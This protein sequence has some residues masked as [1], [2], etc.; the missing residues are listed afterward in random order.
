MLLSMR[1]WSWW[2]DPLHAYP[3]RSRLRESC[4][5]ISAS[6]AAKQLVCWCAQWA[7]PARG[8]SR[9]YEPCGG[10]DAVAKQLSSIPCAM[11]RHNKLD[12]NHR[13]QPRSRSRMHDDAQRGDKR[14]AIQNLCWCSTIFNFTYNSENKSIH[15]YNF[16]NWI[17]SFINR[18][19]NYLQT[20]TI[21]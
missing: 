4:G 21:P 17:F 11:G 16:E 13:R 2:K 10:A 9:I 7:A 18:K 6:V 14:D 20:I 8:R 5:G 15:T 19:N 12:L 3:T 1:S